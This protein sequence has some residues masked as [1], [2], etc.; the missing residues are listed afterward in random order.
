MDYQE[1]IKM[2]DYLRETLG[3]K[4]SVEKDSVEKESEYIIHDKVT[5]N[6]NFLF[7]KEIDIRATSKKDALEKNGKGIIKFHNGDVY[8]GTWVNNNLKILFWGKGKYTHNNGSFYDGEWQN[9]MRHG[10]GVHISVI[11]N[12]DGGKEKDGGK[13]GEKE[14]KEEK[15]E[16]KILEYYVF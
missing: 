14:E 2:E 3:E 8:E 13:E 12:G 6:I 4:K 15:K 11:E 5:D 16:K 7:N 10:Q 1:K 9:G